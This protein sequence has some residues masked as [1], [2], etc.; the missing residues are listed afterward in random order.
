MNITLIRDQERSS[1]DILHILRRCHDVQ[2]VSLDVA[3]NTA[4]NKSLLVVIDADL[5]HRET[6]LRLHELFELD[7]L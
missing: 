2:T 5:N 6:V 7:G 3:K 1:E 4:F